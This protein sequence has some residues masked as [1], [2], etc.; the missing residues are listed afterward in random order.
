MVVLKVE[1]MGDLKV[2]MGETMAVMMAALLGETVVEMM[3]VKTV[4]MMV[5]L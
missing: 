5:P 1:K 2:L 4:V 3:V